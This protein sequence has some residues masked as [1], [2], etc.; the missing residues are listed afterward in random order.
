MRGQHPER[1]PALVKTP[2]DC[3]RCGACCFSPAEAFVRVTGPDWARLGDAAE[4][5]AHFIV[6]RAYMKMADGHCAALELR[7]TP[8]GEPEFFCTVY[9]NRPQ[10]CRDL[11]RGS[12]ECEGERSRLG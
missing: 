7:T 2:T 12:P 3:L 8:A 6:H 4:R 1:L 9:E 5:L 11:A 10:I